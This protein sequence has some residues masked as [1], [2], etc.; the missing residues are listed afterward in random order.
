MLQLHKRPLLW[1]S[2]T[3]SLWNVSHQGPTVTC[4][5]VW[6]SPALATF[7]HYLNVLRKAFTLPF[8]HI[9]QVLWKFVQV[10]MQIVNLMFIL[11]PS[12]CKRN[13]S[14]STVCW[15]LPAFLFPRK[16]RSTSENAFRALAFVA[17]IVVTKW[18]PC[19]V[20]LIEV[21][22][23]YLPFLLIAET[24][25]VWTHSYSWSSLHGGQEPWRM[26][27]QT[28]FYV[29]WEKNNLFSINQGI[30]LDVLVSRC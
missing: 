17:F 23:T 11:H 25:K 21:R 19:W 22:Q 7:F 10:T 12:A 4:Q 29:Q 5:Y 18:D 24:W 14:S 9:T 20:I 1:W 28:K 30:I 13:S 8:A 16:F 3:Y 27:H 2:P 26:L 15:Q 6:V